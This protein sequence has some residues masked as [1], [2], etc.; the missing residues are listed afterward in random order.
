MALTLDQLNAAT[1][2]EVAALLDGIYE[3]S[4]WIAERGAARAA[5][6]LARAPEARAGA[7]RAPAARPTSSWR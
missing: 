5:L 3:H 1:P 7:G 2:A 6:P 4:P